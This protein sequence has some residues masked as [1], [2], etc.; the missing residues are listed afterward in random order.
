LKEQLDAHPLAAKLFA[1]NSKLKAEIGEL[2]GE[3]SEDRNSTA[4]RLQDNT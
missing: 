1:E 3:L 2:K 4:A